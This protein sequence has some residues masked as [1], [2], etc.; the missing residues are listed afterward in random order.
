MIESRLDDSVVARLGEADEVAIET[1]EPV[2]L[3]HHDPIAVASADSKPASN[4]HRPVLAESADATDHEASPVP[5]E[6]E[7]AAT[8]LALEDVNTHPRPA[9]ARRGVVK[10]KKSKERRSTVADSARD[11]LKGAPHDRGADL[12]LNDEKSDSAKS[13]AS[14]PRALKAL[15][16]Q[17]P[18]PIA[19]VPAINSVRIEKPAGFGD[20]R[21]QAA[22]PSTTIVIVEIVAASPKKSP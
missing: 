16:D 1:G 18:E 22:K 7:L 15:I 10:L 8:K 13:P 5:D 17:A 12:D 6:P 21:T 20:L 11:A 3:V 4:A 14:N 2:P 9:P 19:H